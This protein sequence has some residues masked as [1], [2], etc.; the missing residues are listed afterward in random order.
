VTLAAPH[1]PPWLVVGVA[2]I[3]FIAMA[4]Y[5]T[6]LAAPDVP[7]ARRRIRRMSLMIGLASIFAAVLG[8]GII[9]PDA[10]RWRYLAAW[11]AASI[12]LVVVVGLALLDGVVSMREHR[13]GLEKLH[14]ER[15]AALARDIAERRARRAAE[16]DG[17]SGSS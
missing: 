5:W 14:A 11:A 3:L 6:R 4:W 8:F 7:P 13:R 16:A 9:D 12:G 15:N 17:G 2:S 1:L 10:E